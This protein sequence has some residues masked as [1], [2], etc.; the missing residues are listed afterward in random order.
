[1]IG[2]GFRAGAPWEEAGTDATEL[3]RPWG[4]ACFAPTCDFGSK[5]TVAWSTSLRPGMAQQPEP[6]GQLPAKRPEGSAPMPH[7]DMG[8]QYQHAS[9]CGRL[10]AAGIVQSMPRKGN[11]IDNGATEALCAQ[12]H[13]ASNVPDAIMCRVGAGQQAEGVQ[14][15]GAQHIMHR[16][17]GIRGS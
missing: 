6:L 13:K 5:E 8:W 7:S 16:A 4:K 12:A 15:S 17:T 2:R 3:E 1:M 9:W 10:R 11:R 14:P